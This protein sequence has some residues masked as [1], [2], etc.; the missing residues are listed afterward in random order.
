MRFTSRYYLQ[1]CIF[2]GE[3]GSI[4]EGGVKFN[5]AGES[6]DEEFVFFG[7][8]KLVGSRFFVCT[9]LCSVPLLCPDSHLPK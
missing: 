3:F 7:V 8:L 2:A 5:L 6:G 1:K 4:G 9:N